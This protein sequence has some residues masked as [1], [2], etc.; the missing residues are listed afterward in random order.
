[1]DL[2]RFSPLDIRIILRI[3]IFITLWKFLSV[4]YSAFPQL[5][6]GPEFFAL[7]RWLNVLVHQWQGILFD[8]VWKIQALQFISAGLLG[9]AFWR[10]NRLALLLGLLPV[11]LVEWN[12]FL[13]RNQMY[14]LDV[15][16]ALLVLAALGPWKDMV[17]GNEQVTDPATW[18]GVTLTAYLGGAYFLTGWSKLALDPLWWQH[19]R[20]DLLYPTME[21]WHGYVFPD[22]LHSIAYGIHRALLR[23]P[24]LGETAAFLT[25]SLEL[26]WWLS[27]ANRH[28]RT[29]IPFLML[30]C[31]LFIFLSSG[32]LFLTLAVMAA[33]LVIPWRHGFR[34]LARSNRIHAL[35]SGTS[36]QAVSVS[37]KSTVPISMLLCALV[38]LWYPTTADSVFP[39]AK[40]DQF[41]WH[42]A[43]TAEP[44]TVYR[45]G[46][47]DS[48]AR[49]FRIIP[50][51][52]GGFLDYRIVTLPGQHIEAWLRARPLQPEHVARVKQFIR[53]IRSNNSDRWLLGPLAFPEHFIA[54]SED[55]PSAWLKDVYLLEGRYRFVNNA[56]Q[57]SWRV[58]G[59]F[60]REDG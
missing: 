56:L 31:H 43:K 48:N 57:S 53:A 33:V 28:A 30:G 13:Y 52:Y 36:T 27:L 47:L 17:T 58:L 20:L 35:D 7:P 46:Y 50:I 42:Y 49:A 1:M 45:L 38:L 18:A 24:W 32:I 9:L 26:T 55:I 2:I 37:W 29:W 22:W 12:A 16:V 34:V 40:Y 10:L 19:V 5:L 59:K 14:D 44:A 54:Y 51:N 23:F 60:R 11:I 4:D 3:A 6:G 39:F 21:V 8:Q 25:L 15:P 41:G